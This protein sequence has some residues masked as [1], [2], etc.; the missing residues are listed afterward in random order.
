MKKDV[1]SA[2]KR[3]LNKVRS[4][5]SGSNY[6][7]WIAAFL[8]QRQQRVVVGPSSFSSPVSGEFFF[9]LTLHYYFL[10][11]RR[12]PEEGT[13]TTHNTLPSH[14]SGFEIRSRISSSYCAESTTVTSGQLQVTAHEE[15]FY[16]YTGQSAR[17]VFR[18]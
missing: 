14:N 9:F 11:L 7:E 16:W 1:L 5:G 8:T 6:L 2:N 18:R 10:P 17:F 12:V 4:Y 13:Q 15:I 3:L